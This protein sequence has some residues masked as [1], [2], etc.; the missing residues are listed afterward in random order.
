MAGLGWALGAMAGTTNASEIQ[1]DKRHYRAQMWIIGSRRIITLP[2]RWLTGWL[3]GTR[4]K[5][6]NNM[7]HRRHQRDHTRRSNRAHVNRSSFDSTAVESSS[8]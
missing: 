4:H 8:L 6:S 2:M 3:A 5:A 7:H 1:A